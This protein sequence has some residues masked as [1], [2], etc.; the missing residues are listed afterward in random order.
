MTTA[1]N[2]NT[3]ATTTIP[4][5]QANTVGKSCYIGFFE[6][7]IDSI[8]NNAI[9]IDTGFGWDQ[10][11]G[12]GR[13]CNIV[14]NLHQ[15]STSTS[16]TIYN[17]AFNGTTYVSNSAECLTTGNDKYLDL[18]PDADDQV[19]TM[20]TSGD[21]FAFSMNLG[22]TRTAGD[23]L[24]TVATEENGAATP[25]PTLTIDYVFP[26]EAT[27]S[28][29]ILKIGDVFKISATGTFLQNA[30]NVE[31]FT[32]YQLY[33]NSTLITSNSTLIT[34]DVGED[35]VYESWLYVPDDSMRNVTSIISFTNGGYTSELSNV[36]QANAARNYDPN[37]FTAIDPLEGNVN[38]TFVA[39]NL[40][41][42]NRDKNGT[43]FNIECQYFTQA[44][45]FLNNL[46]MGTWEN[47]S[48]VMAYQGDTFGYYYVQCFNSGELF[49]TSIPQNYS[50]ALVPGLVIFDQLGGFFGA[51]SIILVILAILSLGTGRNYPIILLIAASVTGILLALQLIIL[52]PG[53]VVA[54]IVIAGI[55]LFGIRKFY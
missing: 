11:A 38:Y 27:L 21:W 3:S 25:K 46:D 53:L 5:T 9:I 49:V 19:Q 15:P 13:E 39:D 29:N 10:L 45:A 6:F 40:I 4:S 37:H 51:P 32:S 14:E 2:I 16:E 54:L 8:P 41:N 7:P 33:S 26:T 43:L 24:S 50:N 20:L 17:E 31:N 47:K 42:V 52:D 35:I 48:N 44:D 55:G 12:S 34:A 22:N 23:Y 1:Y 18:G 28:Q 36:T 30:T